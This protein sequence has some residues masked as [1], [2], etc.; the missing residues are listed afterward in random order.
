MAIGGGTGLSTLLKGLKR[1]D[2]NITAVV[3]VTDEGGS[4]GR[5]REELNVP[6]PGDVRNN[7]VSL[8]EEEEL[9]EKLFNFRFKNGS[10]QGHTVGNVILAA[11]TMMNQGSLAKA[12][13]ELSRIL[14]IRGRILPVSDELVRLVAVMEDGKEIVGETEIVK[15]E[16]KIREIKLDRRVKPL[17]DVI[18][19]IKNADVI[20]LGPGS[21]YTSVISPLLIKE[22]R[23]TIRNT[24]AKKIYVANIM[25]Q[26]GETTGMSLSDHLN[27]IEKYLHCKVDY[28]LANTAS[29]PKDV[30]ERYE[31][32]GYHLVKLDVENIERMMIL[33]PMI[34]IVIDP[35]D[36]KPK[37]RH[38]PEK[39]AHAIHKVA[40]MG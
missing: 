14:A 2:F 16:G 31:R 8:S 23:D 38:D 10:L 36:E 39:L 1:L 17:K 35:F 32:E 11:L 20:T 13:E 40:S 29:P 3:A 27:E 22:V 37:I 18:E 34:K 6:P 26:P 15:Y 4:S 28:V 19:A 9:L 12:V 21:L 5:L 7:F 30:L 25:T 33:E 24:P